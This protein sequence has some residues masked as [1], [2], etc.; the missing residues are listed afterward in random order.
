MAFWVPHPVQ[1]F[2]WMYL[3]L[4]LSVIA[5]TIA[6]ALV[7]GS[8][9][10]RAVSRASAAGHR[11]L[12]VS[13]G[14]VLAVSLVLAA[15]G[16]LPYGRVPGEGG[17]LTAYRILREHQTGPLARAVA[18]VTSEGT[19]ADALLAAEPLAV[20]EREG[21]RGHPARHSAAGDT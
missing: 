14:A 21:L 10:P 5:G 18:D 13:A 15:A 16:V 4:A 1:A 20:A 17:S 6:L 19:A 8:W 7:G 2:H 3:P 11:T 12:A 9:V